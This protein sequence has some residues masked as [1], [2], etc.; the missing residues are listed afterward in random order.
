[1]N[2]TDNF[3]GIFNN[4]LRLLGLEIAETCAELFFYGIYVHFFLS[5]IRNLSRRVIPLRRP[6]LVSIWIMFLF[7][8]THNFLQLSNVITQFRLAERVALLQIDPNDLAV[9]LRLASLIDTLETAKYVVFSINNLFT[10]IFLLYRCYLIW[11][12]RFG[13]I[14]LPG[15]LITSVCVTG[16]LAVSSDLN[17]TSPS[18]QFEPTFILATVTNITITVLTAGRIW[19]M[20]RE[21]SRLNSGSRSNIFHKRYTRATR[22]IL[23]SGALYCIGEII[24]VATAE[25]NAPTPG[26]IQNITIAIS[27][28]A[29]NIIPTLAL[30]LGTR[31]DPQA[32]EVARPRFTAPRKAVTIRPVSN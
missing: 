11:N 31:E 2:H 9:A 19:W 25:S 16:T 7:G 12:R 26:F 15:V 20:T 5:A 13:V 30:V 4:S 23:E 29:V 22:I 10:D 6:L 32:I 17:N 3:Q 1:M 18:S 21:A 14:I 24:L 8:T 28:Q 27:M